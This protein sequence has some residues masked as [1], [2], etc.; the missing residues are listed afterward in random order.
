MDTGV[1][2]NANL[3]ALD[4]IHQRT[5]RGLSNRV[6]EANRQV[7]DDS[8]VRTDSRNTQGSHIRMSNLDYLN[9]QQSRE[10]GTPDR[11]QG[12]RRDPSSGTGGLVDHHV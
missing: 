11:E 2:V 10:V 8:P 4:I 12:A 5:N 3:F 9:T 6:N 1:I 7:S